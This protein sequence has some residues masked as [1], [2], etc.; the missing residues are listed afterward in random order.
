VAT[1]A[2]DHAVTVDPLTAERIEVVRGPAGLLFGSTTVGGVV[3][4]VREDVPRA[5]PA[6]LGATMSVQGESA[7][8]GLTAGGVVRA[9]V[10]PVALRADYSG[11][12]ANDSRTPRGMLPYTDLDGSSAGVGASVV[13][14]RGFVGGAVRDVRNFYGVPATFGGRTI[15][16]AHDGGVYVD[17]H[18]VSGRVQGELRGGAGALRSLHL[19]G[20]YSWFKQ[21]EVER[22]GVTGTE[23]G[24]LLGTATLL[25]RYRSARVPGEG[26]VGAWALGRDWAAAG[27]YTGTRPA[28]QVAWAG[29]AYHELARG[30]VRV[31]VGGRYDRTRLTPLDTASS[32]IGNNTLLTNIRERHFQALTGSASA[33][34]EVAPSWTAGVTL[35]R[36]FRAPA[37]EELYSNGPHLANYAYEVGNPTL[38]PEVGLGGD[39]FVRLRRTQ[40]TGELTVFATRIRDYVRYAPLLDARTGAPLRDYRLRR[41]QVYQAAQADAAFRGAEGQVA[42]QPWTGWAVEGTAQYVRGMDVASGAPLPFMPPLQGRVGVRRD[43]ARYFAGV[44]ADWSARQRRVPPFPGVLASDDAATAAAGATLLP[45]EF[46]PTNGRLLLEATA[47]LRIAL[48]GRPHTVTLQVDNLL[49]RPWHDAL[50][51]IKTVAPQPGR[52]LRLLYRVEL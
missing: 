4:V 30:P 41:Y 15:P 5:L 40:L 33:L 48:R 49:D 34:Y 3:N 18:R 16:G 47:G 22:G 35:A 52:N 36:S 24:Q 28:R 21:S 37:V 7:N 43:V 20:G 42:W 45:G 50:S 12:T 19:D 46:V 39:L 27:S 44:G 13:G 26:A 38:D 17:L 6:R 11:R 25:A 31:Q 10:G 23:F 29:F 14:A 2:A 32:R 1:T 9:R 8:A 51:R